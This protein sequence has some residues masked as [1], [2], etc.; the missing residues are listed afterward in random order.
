MD[1]KIR[2]IV[3]TVD[4]MF[5]EGFCDM[6]NPVKKCVVAAII[7][8]PYHGYWVEDISELNGVGEMLGEKLTKI[9]FSALQVEAEGIESYGKGAIV[10]VNGEIEHA[11]AIIHPCMGKSM[12]SLLKGGKAIIPSTAKVA[13]SGATIDIPLHHKDAAFVC[14]HWDSFSTC[15]ADAPL[16]DE[17]V[18]FIAYAIGGRPH[19]RIPGLRKNGIIGEN[20]LV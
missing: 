7:K 13:A 17:I 15:I 12:R 4:E 14:T 19:P 16:P 8:N 3:T 2:K 10:G 9:A 20:G 5:Y 6:E 18:I 11:A 1:I